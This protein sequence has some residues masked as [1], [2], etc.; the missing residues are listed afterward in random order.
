M[1]PVLRTVM[2]TVASL[3]GS[4]SAV[5]GFRSTHTK[6]CSL[7]ACA[8][9]TVVRAALCRTPYG[10]VRGRSE[11]VLRECRTQGPGAAARRGSGECPRVRPCG[12]TG[13]DAASASVAAELFCP[14]TVFEETS[15]MP[16]YLSPGVYVEEVASGS[17]PIEGVGTSVA[18]FVGLA[19]RGALNA[20]TLVTNWSQYVAEFGEFTE[21]YYLAHSV[22]GF[23][24]NG[25][26][27]CLRG[28]RRRHRGRPG[29]SGHAD[30][31]TAAAAPAPR[32][33][34]R[35]ERQALTAGEP[36]K[37]SAASRSARSPAHGPG[38]GRGHRRPGRR[39]RQGRRRRGP[40][41]AGGQGRRQGR[42][43]LRRLGAARRP[44]RSYVITQVQASAPR[45]I[46]RGGGR[47]RHAGPPDNQTVQV[48]D[49]GPAGRRARPAGAERRGARCRRARTSATPPTAPA[50][51][52]WRRSTRS[53]WSRSPT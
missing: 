11:P 33:G 23:F 27:V 14:S 12:P 45:S 38:L 46:I 30:G 21:G 41:H 47:L 51:A 1:S 44:A 28:P 15:T 52:A 7:P 22:Y 18:A 3:P 50:S 31:A 32:R 9:T 34:H 48:A 6:H 37:R 29:R 5:T 8:R 16:T 2:A 35:P 39:G 36:V 26:T 42:R 40:L 17:R 4:T 20:P 49:R 43:D 24:N 19:P 25:G 53:P 10:P 13:G